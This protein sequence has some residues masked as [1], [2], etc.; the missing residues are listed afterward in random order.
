MDGERKRSPERKL[1]LSCFVYGHQ[2]KHTQNNYRFHAPETCFHES[3]HIF[4]EKWHALKTIYDLPL[5]LMKLRQV[6]PLP[7][8]IVASAAVGIVLMKCLPI[9]LLFLIIDYA[10]GHNIDSQFSRAGCSAFYKVIN[11]F[12][13]FI[14]NWRVELATFFL[15]F[16]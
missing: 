11:R 7:F 12:A 5:M 6:K 4:S 13:Y 15:L 1:R 2:N 14:G 9:L 16:G 8:A 10:I 3:E